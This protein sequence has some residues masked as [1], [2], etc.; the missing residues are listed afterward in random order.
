MAAVDLFPSSSLSEHLSLG[1]V[2]VMEEEEEE[3]DEM[4]SLVAPSSPG[5]QVFYVDKLP[6]FLLLVGGGGGCLLFVCLFW[7]CCSAFIK[8]K[9]AEFS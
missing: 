4:I 5:L 8:G 2:M 9:I 6:S 7:R 3:E 1:I